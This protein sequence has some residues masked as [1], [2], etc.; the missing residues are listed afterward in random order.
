MLDERE[1][2]D[3]ENRKDAG[4][5]IEQKAAEK[6]QEGD[7]EQPQIDIDT[8]IGARDSDA[9]ALGKPWISRAA[10]V[11]AWR[12]SP[13][14]R[15]SVSTR[16]PSSDWPSASTRSR[17]RSSDQP[18]LV[19]LPSGF[20]NLVDQARLVGKEPRFA[21]ALEIDVDS[22][23]EAQCRVVIRRHGGEGGRPGEG[24]RAVPPWPLRSMP[25][26]W[27]RPASPSI[28][29][30]RSS[31][32]VPVSGMQISAQTSQ[33]AVEADRESRAGGPARRGR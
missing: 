16:T 21:Q 27:G 12:T 29:T 14:G 15:S 9:G 33:S 7:L 5:E 11:N 24:P 2:L 1:C 3:R 10:T 23:H 19:D 6:R 22:G 18:V 4:H 20:G 30:G 17:T 25:R 31:A 26:S 13:S 8:D 32:K 28:S